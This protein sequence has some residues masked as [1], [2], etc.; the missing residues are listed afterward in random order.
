M[1]ANTAR[2]TDKRREK[3]RHR[4]QQDGALF[5]ALP[6]PGYPHQHASPEKQLVLLELYK[7]I[8]KSWRVLVE[9]RCALLALVPAASALILTALFALPPVRTT[10]ILQTGI[11]LF[12]LL[13]TGGLFVY[14]RR[15]SQLHDDLIRRAS[16]IEKEVGTNTGQFLDR[17]RP[18]K[19]RMLLIPFVSPLLNTFELPLGK[20]FRL[21]LPESSPA[22]ILKNYTLQ[23]PKD[24][25]LELL[26][27]LCEVRLPPRSTLLLPKGSILRL[28]KFSKFLLLKGDHLQLRED[29]VL[30]L[31]ENSLGQVFKNSPLQLPKDCT[32][33]QLKNSRLLLATGP[34]HP[35]PEGNMPRLAI[36]S[37]RV[38]AKSGVQLLDDPAV[39]WQMTRIPSLPKN[40]TVELPGKRLL[41]T[42]PVDQDVGAILIYRTTLFAWL[43]TIPVIW[44]IVL[45]P[46]L[47][48]R[49]VP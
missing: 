3:L 38:P 32:W 18:P 20:E 21:H 19:K 33:P 9:I 48:N 30:Q 15:N 11:A 2:T 34:T 16:E 41:P 42:I 8:C 39:F 13:V 27:D 1:V 45:I 49:L 43:V 25:V 47:Y 24:S 23:L 28:P 6:P 7:E 31:P 22:H 29:C 40:L 12:G 10:P 46:L 14:D 17:L 26:D 5:P 44:L 37:L 35:S 4:L 36:K